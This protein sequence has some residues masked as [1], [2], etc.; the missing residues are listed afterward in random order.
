M[1]DRA[2]LIRRVRFSSHTDEDPQSLR[3]RNM[4][5]V[6]VEPEDPMNTFDMAQIVLSSIASTFRGEETT[7]D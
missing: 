2:S 7:D 3:R 4:S 6:N 1:D 5:S